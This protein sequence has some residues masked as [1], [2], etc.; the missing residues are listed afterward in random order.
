MFSP[1][2]AWGALL[3]VHSYS[4][5]VPGSTSRPCI[6]VSL[7]L[8][9]TVCPKLCSISHLS[10]CFYISQYSWRVIGARLC[11]FPH[12]WKCMFSLSWISVP[13]IFSSLVDSWWFWS[14]VFHIIF[15]L[16]FSFVLSGY[17]GSKNLGCYS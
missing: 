4:W 10:H 14:N 6:L 2:E 12:S 13:Q 5:T 8:V 7:S 1:S 16:A 17:V 11:L 9:P 3:P 15:C